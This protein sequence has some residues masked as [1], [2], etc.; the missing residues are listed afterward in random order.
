MVC[1]KVGWSVGR[2]VSWSVG[3]SVGWSVGRLV[4]GWVAVTPTAYRANCCRREHVRAGAAPSYFI[5][6]DPVWNRGAALEQR[7]AATLKRSFR[8]PPTNPFGELN[9][10]LHSEIRLDAR[11]TLWLDAA[12]VA[13]AKNETG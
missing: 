2:L 4:G 13:I 11:I 6:V 1:P 12:D 10:H 3:R 9:I 8:F 7:L 5:M